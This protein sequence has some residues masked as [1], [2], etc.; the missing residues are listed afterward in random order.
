MRRRRRGVRRRPQKECLRQ[1][2]TLNVGFTS[3]FEYERA[4]RQGAERLAD[5]DAIGHAVRFHPCGHVHGVAPYVLGKASIADYAGGRGA[6]MQSD[7]QPH[8]LRTEWR[9]AAVGLEHC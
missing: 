5:V 4:I 6:A 9:A 3:L 1:P 2:D 8:V 7:S